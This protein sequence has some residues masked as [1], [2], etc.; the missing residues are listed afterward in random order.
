MGSTPRMTT[1]NVSRAGERGAGSSGGHHRRERVRRLVSASCPGDP[2]VCHFIHE[3]DVAPVKME[4][5]FTELLSL[6]RSG[7]RS[8]LVSAP[9]RQE[10]RDG[11][12][13]PS[14]GPARTGDSL[15]GRTVTSAMQSGWGVTLRGHRAK[16]CL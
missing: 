1:S 3:E 8:R 10:C 11:S 4:A 5:T 9:N 7:C 15:C 6:V 2:A 14:V 16:V 13:P 12:T